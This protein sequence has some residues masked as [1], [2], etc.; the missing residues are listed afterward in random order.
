[1]K[2]VSD[3]LRFGSDT[4]HPISSLKCFNQF[5]WNNEKKK[6]KKTLFVTHPN[7]LRQWIQETEHS[8]FVLLLL[9][10]DRNAQRHKRFAEI[11][12]TFPLRCDCH[13]CNG[14]VG[15]LQNNE[16]NELIFD[17]LVSLSMNCWTSQRPRLQ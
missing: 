7:L 11:D 15:F 17:S 8:R 5:R 10:H 9:G 2:D 14:N 13:G 6:R 16:H 3:T 12:D 4:N 1:M